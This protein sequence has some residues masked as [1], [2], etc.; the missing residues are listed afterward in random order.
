[1]PLFETCSMMT[2]PALNGPSWPGSTPCAASGAAG[3][4]PWSCIIVANK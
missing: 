3:A 1:M 2:S 4:G